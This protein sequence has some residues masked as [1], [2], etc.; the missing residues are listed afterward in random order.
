M[1]ATKLTVCVNG[2]LKRLDTPD[3]GAHVAR[4]KMPLDEYYYHD[5]HTFARIVVRDEDGSEVQ[6]D[7]MLDEFN[8]LELFASSKQNQRLSLFVDSD[9][10]KPYRGI[11]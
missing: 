5:I 9:Y 1:E 3:T 8:R 2:E 10:L 4:V 6:V 7:L 11:D